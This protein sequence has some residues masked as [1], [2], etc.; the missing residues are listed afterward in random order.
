MGKQSSFT[1]QDAYDVLCTISSASHR[2]STLEVDLRRTRKNVSVLASRLQ[3]AHFVIGTLEEALF[4]LLPPVPILPAPPLPP[5]P[6]VVMD[7]PASEENPEPL[8]LE[9]PASSPPPLVPVMDP[10]AS[11]EDPDPTPEPLPPADPILPAPPLPPRPD[12]VMDPPA[13]QEDPDPTPS[14]ADP[15]PHRD[16]PIEPLLSSFDPG[17]PVPLILTSSPRP[18]KARTPPELPLPDRTGFHLS[19]WNFPSTT[20]RSLTDV[21]LTPDA[22]LVSAAALATDISSDDLWASLIDP[23]AADRF[24]RRFHPDPAPTPLP[25]TMTTTTTTRLKYT[26][27]TTPASDPIASVDPLPGPDFFLSPPAADGTIVVANPPSPRPDP[28]PLPPD[29]GGVRTQRKKRRSRRK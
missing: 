16:S 14:P 10:P 27:A 4:P 21:P 29:L 8:P 17:T 9:A 22:A 7:P 12:M 28:S 20:Y 5:R 1:R 23:A 15:L 11:Q 13:S 19:E 25:P 24:V 26:S 3:E 6:D 2:N 18:P